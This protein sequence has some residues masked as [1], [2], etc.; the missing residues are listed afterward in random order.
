M[1]NILVLSRL[2]NPHNPAVAGPRL[3]LVRVGHFGGVA[4]GTVVGVIRVI[5]EEA[6]HRRGP[7]LGSIDLGAACFL[8]ETGCTRCLFRETQTP[9]GRSDSANFVLVPLE[10]NFCPQ[11]LEP[12]PEP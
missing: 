10:P 12:R 5:Q 4:G 2:P 8:F 9:R 6:N 3:H 1:S 7:N 11:I